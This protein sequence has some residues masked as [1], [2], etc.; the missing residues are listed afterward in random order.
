MPARSLRLTLVARPPVPH[1]RFEIVGPLVT[2]P[3]STADR[4]HRGDVTAPGEA[5]HLSDPGEFPHA[6]VVAEDHPRILT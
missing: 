6:H 5:W 4:Q 2:P 1:D 3:Q